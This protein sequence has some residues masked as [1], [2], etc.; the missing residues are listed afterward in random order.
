MRIAIVIA[1]LLIAALPATAEVK[2]E[3]AEPT[4][5]Y[6]EF[7]PKKP[8]VLDPPFKPGEAAACLYRFEVDADVAFATRP[9]RAV[10]GSKGEPPVDV[11]ISGLTVRLKLAITIWLPTGAS[12]RLKEHEEGHRRLA[13]AYYAKAEQYARA[14]AAKVDGKKFVAAALEK[15]K[16]EI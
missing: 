10:P 1:L 14:Q 4:V 6:K 12:D 5:E 7:D 13:E 15:A 2:V 16:A 9:R 8:P 11:V 3:K